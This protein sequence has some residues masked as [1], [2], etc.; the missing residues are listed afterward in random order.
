MKVKSFN[1]V[2]YFY[3]NLIIKQLKPNDILLNNLCIF[4]KRFICL[5]KN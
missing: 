4:R 3:K 2:E 5:F 1:G